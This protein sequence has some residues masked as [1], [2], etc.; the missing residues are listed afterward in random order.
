MPVEIDAPARAL[1][2]LDK[3]GQAGH[4]A[5]L[6]GG[7]VR[8]SLLGE[9]PK[10]W[11]IATAAKPEEVELVFAGLPVLETG[12]QHGTVT[13]LLEQEPFEIT[14]FRSDGEYSDHRRPSSVAF[15]SDLKE[16]L[17]RRD[18]TVNALA[19]SPRSGLV[20]YFHGERD[21]HAGRIACVGDPAARFQEDALRILRAV[22]FAST[23]EF[24][25]EAATAVAMEAHCGLLAYIA[26]ERIRAEL[27]RALLG[28]GVEQAYLRHTAV[29]RQISSDFAGEITGCDSEA[30]ALA[31]RAVSHAPP[32]L[33]VRLGL[34]FA[35]GLSGGD[36]TANAKR[37]GEVLARLRYDNQTRAQVERLLCWQGERVQP[38]PPSVKRWLNRLGEEDFGRLLHLRRALDAAGGEGIDAG[39]LAQV[40][41]TLEQI[42]AQ[43]QCY[44]MRDLAVNGGDLL[45][46][47]APKGRRVGEILAALLE[48]VIDEV[49][50][51]EH[52]VLLYKAKQLIMTEQWEDT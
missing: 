6:V 20:D 30:W 48:D 25:V 43:G 1:Y 3:L 33:P 41:Q 27:D 39:I 45:A 52:T 5:Y 13:V 44:R 32:D 42:H 47:G 31:L 26:P 37:A 8:D 49:L 2:L 23:L 19:W 36:H 40:R 12:L 15:V 11:D 24:T 22:R 38:N 28:P 7:C 46:A 14:T 4:E 17:A 21:L 29:I 16:D 35:C 34:L 51:N 9:T 18:F 50:P 10:D